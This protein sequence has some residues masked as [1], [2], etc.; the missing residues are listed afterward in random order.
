MNDSVGGELEVGEKF[1]AYHVWPAS[2]Y[3]IL[4]GTYIAA[5]RYSYASKTD[6]D[7]YVAKG[8]T[9]AEAIEN[10]KRAI[11]EGRGVPK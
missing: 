6:E 5:T 3:G 2:E 4:R 11:V 1:Y 10:L 9:Q 7:F 8:H